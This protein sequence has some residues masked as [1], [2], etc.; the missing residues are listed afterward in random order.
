MPEHLTDDEL[1]QAFRDGL[2]RHAADAPTRLRDGIPSAPQER[3]ASRRRTVWLAAAAAAVVAVGV[4]VV[5]QLSGGGSPGVP[6]AGGPSALRTTAL[7]PGVTWRT[8]S[9]AGVELQ[10]PSTWGWGGT[11]VDPGVGGDGVCRV[12]GA[13]VAPDGQSDPNAALDLP[14]VGRPVLQSDACAMVDR[15]D[16]RPDVDAVWFASPRPVGSSGDSRTVEVAGIRVTVFTGNADLRE[17]ILG[18]VRD[19]GATDGNGCATRQGRAEDVATE[20]AG[21]T[22]DGLVVCA[23][24]TG[25]LLFG[26]TR[27]ADAARAYEEAVRRTMAIDAVGEE[28]CPWRAEGE[29]VQ[30]GLRFSDGPTRW[31]RMVW[32]CDHVELNLGAGMARWSV[33][34]V[35]AWSGP[36]SKAYLIGPGPSAGELTDEVRGLFRGILG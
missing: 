35:R 24:S 4:P 3:G 14:Y 28:R 1:E 10:V 21:T 31:D 17:H 27:P 36:E 13:T 30:V 8:E 34:L 18:T 29:S 11:P 33:D 6:G 7:P 12:A 9:Y 2:R 23:Y 26:T 16:A 19:V 15:S 32:T 20:R 5:V 22:P 25:V